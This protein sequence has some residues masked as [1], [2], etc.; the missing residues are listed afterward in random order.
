MVRTTPYSHKLSIIIVN[1]NVRYFLEQCL[2]SV[3]LAISQLD[4]EVIVVD[5][6]SVDGSVDYISHKYPWVQLIANTDNVGFSK[7]NN[8][9][10]RISRG[11]YVLLLNPDTLVEKDT[12]TKCIAYL[13]SHE[14]VGGLGVKMVDGKGDFLPESKR[15]LPTPW[16]A[17]YKIF[18]F[19]KL[20]PRS[21][22]F[23]KYHLTY[24]PEDATNE[25][26]ILSGA[27]MLMRKSVLEIVGLLDEDFFMY[28][29]DIDLSYRIT[30]AGFK[31]V[32]FPETRIIHY[33]GESTKRASLNYV[34]L[35]YNAMLI[36]AQKHFSS[37]NAASYYNVVR[38]AVYLRA[39]YSLMQRVV[40]SILL[41][42][43]DFAL[44]WV[45]MYALKEF[46][47]TYSKGIDGFYPPGYM[48]LIVP[49]YCIAW[50]LCGLFFGI[51]SRPYKFSRIITASL[52][53][54]VVISGVTN[55]IDEYRFSKALIILGSCATILSF[56]LSRL[57][58]NLRKF[59][60]L[61]FTGGVR[62]RSIVVGSAQECR[63]VSDILAQASA[64]SQ[65]MGWVGTELKDADSQ[66]YLGNYSNLEQL[67]DIYQVNEVIFCGRDISVNNIIEMM[68]KTK[69]QNLQFKISPAESNFIIGSHSAENN[70]EF[71]NLEVK[72]NLISKA[73]LFRKRLLDIALA[74]FLLLLAPFAIWVISDKRGFLSNLQDVFSGSKSWVGLTNPSDLLKKHLRPGVL[75]TTSQFGAQALKQEVIDKIDIT[76]AKEYSIANDL[77]LVLRCFDKLG[78]RAA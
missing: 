38:A 33:K 63:K 56:S 73:N 54:L 69:N 52:V 45:S 75:S 24:L 71:Y 70:G 67:I 31:N 6:A 58:A 60:A 78:N 25:I 26:E 55:F 47:E 9:G 50:M 12:F 14:D 53:G 15:G 11:K 46:W 5:N 10:I 21:S 16:V 64:P 40:Q 37:S 59:G 65:V 32:Y 23:G 30:K 34:F 20:F 19:S 27:F 8:Q 39:F 35:F 41:P 68:S 48:F 57:V 51:Y 49:S 61:S 72:M 74:T 36:F 62:H 28:G 2:N 42:A 18:G 77:N 43:A 66:L 13:D 44:I 29:E 76:Y 17:F 3:Q 4:A 7:A 22:R 1:Y